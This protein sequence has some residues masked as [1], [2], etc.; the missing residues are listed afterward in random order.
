MSNDAK[1]AK[2]KLNAKKTGALRLLLFGFTPYCSLLILF[3]IISKA[4][5]MNFERDMPRSFN[6]AS[7]S[8][9]VSFRRRT[10]NEV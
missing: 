10:E 7:I 4:D 5:F 1:A 9:N 3:C 8:A 6:H 2:R